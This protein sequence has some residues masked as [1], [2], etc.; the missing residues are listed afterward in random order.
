MI[1]TKLIATPACG[2]AAAMSVCRG[3]ISQLRQ[4]ILA[5]RWPGLRPPPQPQ[6]SWRI[7]PPHGSM[8]EVVRDRRG[9]ALARMC[10]TEGLRLSTAKRR[11]ACWVVPVCTLAGCTVS[12][13]APPAKQTTVVLTFDDGPI[14]ADVPIE[15][16]KT[17]GESL[18]DPLRQILGTLE[19]HGVQAVFYVAAPNPND[20]SLTGTWT[21]GVLAAHQAGQILGYHAFQHDA[22][23]WIDP[24]APRATVRAAVLADYS[25]LQAFIDQALVPTGLMQNEVFSPIFRMPHGEGIDGP[26]DGPII[27]R[28]L[29][30][31]C[32]G[33]AIDS[34][35]WTRNADLP[36]AIGDRILAE[37]GGDPVALVE[38]R[39]RQ[40]ARFLAER[41]SVDVLMHVNSLTAAHLDEWIGTLTA[42]FMAEGVDS[43][44]LGVPSSYLAD[45]DPTVDLS[46]L[47]KSLFGMFGQS[48][49]P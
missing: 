19:R 25:D 37:A 9:P 39:L 34:M 26:L 23:F 46:G 1:G 47:M 6:S 45:T 5:D 15:D 30:W 27:A 36:Q 10:R 11:L 17:A 41:G 21:E 18:L 31:T 14:A 28:K 22:S 33:Y 49:A 44:S 38:D 35:D 29:G 24:L 4:T 40:G 2:W 13:L 32:H 12:G 16:R 43:V 7:G 8:E 20:G 42:A 48:Q 3:G